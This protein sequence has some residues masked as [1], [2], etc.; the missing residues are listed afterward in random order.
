MMRTE[1]EV[2]FLDVDEKKFIKKLEKAG[3]VF[4]GDWF[5]IRNVYDLDESQ[6]GVQRW[7]RLRTNGEQTTLAIKEIKSDTIDGT[8][9]LEITV[10]SFDE[11]AAILNK[12]GFAPRGRQESKR[13]SYT[14]DDVEIDIDTWPII[15]TYVEIEGK[16]EQQIKDV[17]VKLGLD[18][19][20]ACTM[21]VKDIILK[22]YKIPKDKI[23]NVSF[24]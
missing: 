18:Y 17:C 11:T 23:D 4:I 12:L 13:K 20:K 6:D 15:P 7:I 8:G 19:E 5:Q 16:N 10:S 1:Y 3:A 2:R 9:E 22:I 14:L 21:G 24:N